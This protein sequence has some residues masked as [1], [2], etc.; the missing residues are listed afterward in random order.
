MSTKTAILEALSVWSECG[1]IGAMVGE[2][3]EDAKARQLRL[4]S[5]YKL[6]MQDARVKMRYCG[7]W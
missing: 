5:L 4:D 6:A 1:L 3:A 2:V 7:F